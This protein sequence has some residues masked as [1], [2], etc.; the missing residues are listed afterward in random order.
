M[1]IY[2]SCSDPLDFCKQCAPDEGEAE[3]LYGN[4]GDG[5][6]GIDASEADPKDAR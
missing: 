1:R 4:L 6:N 5:P 3:E 2:N